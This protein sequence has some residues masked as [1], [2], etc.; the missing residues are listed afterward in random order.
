MQFSCNIYCTNEY[1]DDFEKLAV[2]FANAVPCRA[3]FFLQPISK[4][5]LEEKKLPTYEL[6]LK[7]LS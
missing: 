2:L 5:V 3:V 6:A 4:R 7:I 1:Q